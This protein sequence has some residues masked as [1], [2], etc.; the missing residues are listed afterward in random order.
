MEVHTVTC[1][2]AEAARANLPL[3][4][5]SVYA[6]PSSEN[7]FI[8]ASNL[9]TNQD[10]ADF[11]QIILEKNI[12]QIVML[13]A[14]DKV[15]SKNYWSRN[16]TNTHG[17]IMVTAVSSTDLNK[18]TIRDIKVTNEKENIS[19]QLQQFQF[20]AWSGF[21]DEQTRKSFISFVL[22]VRKR[23][24]QSIVATAT[25]VYC[26]S[27]RTGV[28]IVLDQIIQ[29]I[30]EGKTVD[31]YDTV[32]NIHT[33]GP[34]MVQTENQY[35]FL[36]QCALDLSKT[37]NVNLDVYSEINDEPLYQTVDKSRYKPSQ[38]S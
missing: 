8:V 15:E 37:E 1:E 19:R 11:W 7:E 14:N 28:F 21:N 10:V 38:S 23:R 4:S 26:S 32:Y 22:E 30:E 5:L 18:W 13:S 2:N 3:P 29:Q 12:N 25:L 34:Q 35:I 24:K 20:T 36:H 33:H 27:G 16:K 6:V 17:D 31:L 9:R